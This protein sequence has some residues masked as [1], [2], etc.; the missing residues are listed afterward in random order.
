M[1]CRSKSSLRTELSL[2][3]LLHLQA[4]VM[5]HTT[6]SCEFSV[7]RSH[8]TNHKNERVAMTQSTIKQDM[9]SFAESYPFA[10]R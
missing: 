8:K 2:F 10:V 4:R 7:G 3:K 1:G 5:N 9:S 6:E